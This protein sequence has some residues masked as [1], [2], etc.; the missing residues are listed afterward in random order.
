MQYTVQIRDTATARQA[1]Q[2]VNVLRDNAVYQR[3][4]F[5]RRERCMGCVGFSIGK[6]L[7]TGKAPRPV[8]APAI[9]AIDELLV[10]HRLLVLPVALIVTVV[11]NA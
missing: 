2:V 3:V 4:V 11:R 5:Q 6:S 10:L 9:G 8:P 1:M 7:P